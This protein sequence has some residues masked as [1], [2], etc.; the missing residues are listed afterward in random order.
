MRATTSTY[1]QLIASNNTR[2]FLVKI[3]MTLADDT[4]LELTN[5]DIWSDSFELETASSNT[6]SFDVGCA[7]IGKCKFQL[8]NF[9][10]RFNSY[11]FFNATAVVW[12]KLDGDSSYYRIGV[13]TVDEPS[14][15]GALISL[16]LLDNM[17]KFDV[18]LSEVSNLSF[19]VSILSAVNTI[20]T[21]CGVT[22]ATQDFHG[23]NFQI[24]E[25]KEDMNCREF[26]QYVAMIGCN[27]CLMDSQGNLNIKW[28]NTSAIPS[29]S[30]LDGGT[31]STN[32]T[33]Y[34]DGDTA[35]GGNFIDYTS[36]DSYDGGTFTDNPNVA[37][38]TRNYSTTLGTDVITI[39][40]LKVTIDKTEYTV[41]SEGY[42][43][44]IDNPL[45][46]VDN[47]SSVLNL[48]WEVLED[49]SFRT[50]SVD[51][52]SDLAIE[53]G[54]CC[55]IMDLH[56]NYAYSFVTNLSYKLT[57]MTASLGAVSPTRTLTKRYSKTVQ[58]AVDQARQQTDAIIS[59]YDLSVQMMNALSVI[60]MGAYRD[61]ED[62]QTGGRIYYLSNM[63]ITKT[64]GTCSFE[65]NSTV[66][67]I[68]GDGFFIS[69]QGGQTGTWNNGYDPIT[70]KLVV[71][72]LN[73]IGLSCDWIKTGT[74]TVGGVGTSNPEIIVKDSGGNTIATINVDG[75][76]MY[77]GRL[78]SA[79]GSQYI[80]LTNNTMRITGN[81]KVK[82]VDNTTTVSGRNYALGTYNG[83]TVVNGSV[84]QGSVNYNASSQMVTDIAN[85]SAVR[86]RFYL[87][88]TNVNVADGT[89]IIR[90]NVHMKGIVAATG[91]AGS[92]NIRSNFVAPLSADEGYFGG[93]LT[94][95]RTYFSS[96]SEIDYCFFDNFA[97]NGTIE[98]KEFKVE[99]SSD[100]TDWT[101]APED[102]VNLQ[103]IIDT[104][105][106][107]G[108]TT[109]I[110][111]YDISLDQVKT[112]NKLTNNSQ[113]EGI[114]L[115]NSHL[116]LNAS[117]IHAGIMTANYIFGG[118]YF[119][120]GDDGGFFAACYPVS[121][122]EADYLEGIVTGH[123]DV[124]KALLTDEGNYVILLNIASASTKINTSYAVK[125][126]TNGG[127]SWSTEKTGTLSK[128][129][130]RIDFCFP[131]TDSNLTYY[132]LEISN[133]TATT[134]TVNYL[135][136]FI[137]T[138]MDSSGITAKA[139]SFGILKILEDGS[140]NYIDDEV[141]FKTGTQKRTYT[142]AST[143]NYAA[144]TQFKP[145]SRGIIENFTLKVRL[146][147]TYNRS[148]IRVVLQLKE[149][150]ST[151]T[152]ETKTVT[153]TSGTLDDVVEFTNIDYTIGSSLGEYYTVRLQS[154]NEAGTYDFTY[155]IYANDINTTRIDKEAFRGTFIGDIHSEKGEI[156]EWSFVDE[157]L[158][159]EGDDGTTSFDSLGMLTNYISGSN[160]HT[161]YMR[162]NSSKAYSRLSSTS[163]SS[164]EY[165]YV[166]PNTSVIAKITISV[167][168]STTDTDIT[169][170]LGSTI[171]KNEWASSSDRRIKEDITP[172]SVELSKALINA[173]ETKRFKYKHEE[174]MHYGMIAQDVR[175]ILD[176]LGEEDATL[177]FSQG[178][179]NVEDERAIKYEEYIP[180]IINYIK[181]LQAQVD[182]QQ[183]ELDSLKEIL[184]GLKL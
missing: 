181:D 163:L 84:T 41:G 110:V 143:L 39:T 85:A 109:G 8:N 13:F 149:N 152:V 28:Y 130:N 56:G 154:D 144:L 12:L 133:N 45:I 169:R 113:D 97:P 138:L 101:Y 184:Q 76:T 173:T 4:E 117:M 168:S 48:M 6:A 142:T 145:Y 158:S 103:N 116:Y 60:S 118:A 18:P 19:P 5:A 135:F 82:N 122:Y 120:G 15:A 107:G 42:V 17:W 180:P 137:H 72:V 99:L 71:N 54:D 62:V 165:I 106:D 96:I 25:P 78:Q 20:C 172:L 37:Y 79:D 132:R 70:G 102:E 131:V 162:A 183:A 68:S 127:S 170:Q 34:S 171:R 125:K 66:F 77:R 178:N 74:L 43:L 27:F 73:A 108:V 115:E 153:P 139:G 148:V 105:V 166:N 64:G 83:F 179:L 75:I 7:V 175:E 124:T 29:E 30:D 36:G 111:N 26:L 38:F 155:T 47:V 151:S 134:I 136:Y 80:D 81:T 22:L 65:P 44:E 1:K 167:S 104:K 182:R 10:E 112:Y 98:V 67:K 23:K 87:K 88:L 174:G 156:G 9:D 94:S 140:L 93:T 176:E 100:F 59:D 119:T 95:Y 55:A 14:F 52:L 57:S 157:K 141:I 123:R 35:D 91:Q 177:E 114:F 63:P 69:T 16:E 146:T 58:Q 126:T 3:N 164:A 33:P 31:F 147:G 159:S 161:A 150:G 128:G 121:V 92:A 53:V 89:P 61:Y 2:K 129:L 24:G 90:A 51:A 86:V 49:F 11:D 50:F 21:H 40:G 32:T 46:T 160:T